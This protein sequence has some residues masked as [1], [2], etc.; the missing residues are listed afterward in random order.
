METLK[1]CVI[2]R[3]N[4]RGM[5]SDVIPSFIRDVA[6]AGTFFH[7]D[8]KAL[9]QRLATLG[10]HEFELDRHTFQMIEA[11]IENEQFSQNLS[12]EEGLEAGGLS[13]PLLSEQTPSPQPACSES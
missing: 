1:R 4:E 12:T 9:N 11:I 8:F 13:I 10:W 7:S 2:K 5:D 6:N 3:L